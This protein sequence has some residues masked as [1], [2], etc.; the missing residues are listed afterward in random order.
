MTKA[1]QDTDVVIVDAA[2]TAMGRSKGGVF[3]HVRADSLSASMV[4]QVLARNPKFDPARVED[5]IWGCVNQYYEQGLNI[6]KGVAILAG[7]PETVAAQTVNRLCGSSMAALHTAAAS[8]KAGMG[9]SFIVGGVEHIGH[10]PMTQGMDIN[11]EL[12]R[13]ISS[14]SMNMGLT[15]EN[16]AAQYK[17]SRE[18]QDE[19][20]LRSHQLAYEATRNGRFSKEIVAVEGHDEQGVLTQVAVDEVIRNDASIE[21]LAGLPPVFIPRKG[22]VTAG[23]ASAIADGASMMLVMS[24]AAAREA[25]ISPIARILSMASAGCPAATMGIGPVPATQKALARANLKLSDIGVFELN[26]AFAAQGIAVLRELGIESEIDSKVNLLGG[27]IALGH[28]FGCSGTRISTT[29]LNAMD[30]QGAS[31]G[32]ATMCIGMGQGISTVFERL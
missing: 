24:G 27:A 25:G 17:V 23:N 20:A 12:S 30:Q 22:S 21:G 10:L 11:P 31:I 8:I 15:A 19:F 28:P 7:V 3:R 13:R 26:E 4:E 1:F 9:D 18:Q 14:H 5:L 16:L 29:L 6:A 32:L 2:R